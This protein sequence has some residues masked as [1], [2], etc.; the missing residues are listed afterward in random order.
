MEMSWP[1]PFRSK[2]NPYSLPSAIDYTMT[3]PLLADGSN[4][5]CKHYQTADMGTPQGR[6][7]A[8]F[9][10]GQAANLTVTGGAPHGGG[11]CQVSVSYDRGQSFTVVQSIEGG[12]PAN[13]GSNTINFAIP[14]DAPQGEAL[15]AWS[16]F[17][18]LG[19][20]E[21]Y[22]NCAP[23]TIS[24]SASKKRDETETEEKSLMKRA[25]HT[26]LNSR[27]K[28]FVANV[29]NGCT[30]VDSRDVKFPQPGPDVNVQSAQGAV[31][32]VGSG[33]QSGVS[34]SSQ[35]GDEVSSAPKSPDSA[36]SPQNAGGVFVTVATSA[37][38][39][40]V[41][42]APTAASAVPAPATAPSAAV[43]PLAVPPAAAVSPA[44]VSAVSVSAP[45]DSAAP[46]ANPIPN[47]P[48]TK[49]SPQPAIGEV[50]SPSTVDSSSSSSAA[51]FSPGTPCTA[52]G[53]WSCLPGGRKFQRCASGRWSAV[54]AMA[55]G[56]VCHVGQSDRFSIE[57][58]NTAPALSRFRPRQLRHG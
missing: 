42:K 40:S 12:C 57:A 15:L 30:T 39:A 2:Y 11:S 56:T 49:G 53:R 14:Y 6:S 19:N 58:E 21:M 35:A 46:A 44:S 4:F 24:G 22:M 18:N 48:A 32:P 55:A 26:P 10:A 7:T 27:P 41:T 13:V 54:Q 52:E 17:N 50:A 36:K 34:V 25:A 28:L 38:F 9:A 8:T 47:I 20:R 33:C 45:S 51:A 3:A 29:G 1:P 5:P 31:A 37:A 23:V 43:A 16:W